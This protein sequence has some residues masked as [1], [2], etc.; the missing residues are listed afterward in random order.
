[1]RQHGI[2]TV[3]NVFLNPFSPLST[4]KL[5][6]LKATV[7]ISVLATLFGTAVAGL[8]C[9]MR[10]SPRAVLNV[11]AQAYI[12][13]LRGTPVLV[14]LMLIFYVVFASVDINPMFV[15]VIAFGLNFGA[16][17]AEILRSGIE[18][19]DPGQGEAGQPAPGY[20]GNIRAVGCLQG[21]E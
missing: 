15:A 8:I 4:A 5:F 21:R 10:M 6:G 16:Y 2:T 19:V 14:L 18:G 20:S 13:V 9:F 1:M 12:A 7:L 17:V 3:P 11:P